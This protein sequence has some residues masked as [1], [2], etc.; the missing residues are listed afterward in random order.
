MW[1]FIKCFFGFHE[2]T[3]SHSKW[4]Q[5]FA[6]ATIT[7]D[8]DTIPPTVKP[9]GSIIFHGNTVVDERY[10]LG[11]WGVDICDHCNKRVREEM[12]YGEW[13]DEL[14]S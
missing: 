9:D 12:T 13:Q 8:Y 5:W 11:R 7:T 4:A 1:T 10:R 3:T 6:G 2:T 14:S